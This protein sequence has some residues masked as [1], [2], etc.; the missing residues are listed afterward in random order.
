MA[1]IRFYKTLSKISLILLNPLVVLLRL[2][3]R[4]PVQDFWSHFK[5]IRIL[6][7]IQAKP[8]N[9]ATFAYK[10]FK[11]LSLLFPIWLHV[12]WLLWLIFGSLLLKAL[13]PF[14]EFP[15]R[16]FYFGNYFAKGWKV[17]FSFKHTLYL[18]LTH[19]R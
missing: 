16:V 12:F 1:V 5:T 2:I 13:A 8:L 7:F 4:D 10:F 19:H 6:F 17:K 3:R 15:Q 11:D 14:V 18:I 9:E